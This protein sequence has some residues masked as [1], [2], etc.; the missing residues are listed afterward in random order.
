MNTQY[1]TEATRSPVQVNGMDIL[2][3]KKACAWA[4]SG[5]TSGKGPL[6][7]SLLPTDMVDTRESLAFRLAAQP[8]TSAGCPTPERPTERVRRSSRSGPRRTRSP[9]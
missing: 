4:K 2:A 9:A 5:V 7:S 6:V 8:L 3:V 1:F